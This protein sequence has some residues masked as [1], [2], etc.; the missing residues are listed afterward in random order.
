M[1]QARHTIAPVCKMQCSTSPRYDEH[2]PEASCA[3]VGWPF[4]IVSL[5]ACFP[6]RLPPMTC[7]SD[8]RRDD[9]PGFVSHGLRAGS[10]S[11][12]QETRGALVKIFSLAFLF[13]ILSR[14][15]ENTVKKQTRSNSVRGLLPEPRSIGI[16]EEKKRDIGVAAAAA[17]M[18]GERQALGDT[19]PAMRNY[20]HK[21]G[22][23]LA[24]GLE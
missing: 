9:S 20:W 22:D 8:M 7:S 13:F 24:A 19:I 17:L 10:V 12:E 5:D 2:T 6:P 4:D 16:V 15:G 1:A 3:T 18:Q 23:S 11:Q 21:D 14:G